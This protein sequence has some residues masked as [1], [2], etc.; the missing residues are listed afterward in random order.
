MG[1]QVLI[2][3]APGLGLQGRHAEGRTIVGG[4]P[5][6]TEKFLKLDFVHEIVDR[7]I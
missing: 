5:E 7:S 3:G 6:R 2:V 4:F 1:K